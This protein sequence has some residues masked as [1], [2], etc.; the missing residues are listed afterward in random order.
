MRKDE[1]VT[2]YWL[3]TELLAYTC[4]F[5]W[6]LPEEYRGCVDHPFEFQE[7]GDSEKYLAAE[8]QKVYDNSGLSVGIK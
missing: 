8:R 7:Y 5:G 4:E 3:P 2:D 6:S 1:L